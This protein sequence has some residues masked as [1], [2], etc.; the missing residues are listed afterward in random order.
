MTKK[1][2]HLNATEMKS[3]MIKIMSGAMPEGE[4]E[5]FLIELRERGESPVEI[6]A[7]AQVMRDNALKLPRE[8][9]DLLDT[10]GTGG[11]SQSTV[12]V[13]TLAA[14]VAASAGARV[15]KH[16]NR[17]VSSV[18]GSADLL[19]KLGVKI[20][21]TPEK[22][23]ACLEKTRFGFF[24]APIFHP[25]VK[26]V[27]PVRRK[28][29]GKTI[30]NILGPL[31]NPANAAYQLI[32]VYEERLVRIVAESLSR[33]GVKRAIVVHGKDGLDEI[34]L[35]GETMLAELDN[36]RITESAVVPEDFGMK[37]E[38]LENLRCHT[39]EENLESA[40]RV[41][42]GDSNAASKIVCLNA[43][44]ALYVAGK[45]NSIKEGVLAA[46]NALESGAAE[47]TLKAVVTFSQRS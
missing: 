13:S 46:M 2:G 33:L 45:A 3:R 24:F 40:R 25:A 17:S 35:S 47:K 18:C 14:L 32:G 43:A 42:A 6:A 16:G 36:G 10:C 26:A 15:A 12:N 34:S 7:A 44:A 9:P 19:E 27:M 11:D 28:I 21:L 29:K 4:I 37:R 20:D 30:F 8:F 41:L 5:A 1:G 39:P 22:V 23:A 38:P 31:S